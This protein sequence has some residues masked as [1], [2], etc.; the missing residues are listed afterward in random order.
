[1]IYVF[2]LYKLFETHNRSKD[3]GHFIILN[4]FE[5]EHTV[6]EEEVPENTILVGV[7]GRDQPVHKH[8]A[9]GRHHYR[10]Q[11]IRAFP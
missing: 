11:C 3:T 5:N 1:M 10:V 6:R 9:G 7:D 8:T 2:V 4:R